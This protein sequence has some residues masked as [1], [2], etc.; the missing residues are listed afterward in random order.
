M[1]ATPTRVAQHA[2]IG[3]VGTGVMGASMCAHLQSAGHPLTVFTRTKAK[4]AAL[5]CAGAAWAEC[6]RAVAEQC[7][8]VCSMVGFPQDVRSVYFG[9]DG[10]LAGAKRGAVLIDFTT[11]EPSLAAEIAEAAAKQDAFAIDAPVSGGDVGARNATLSIMLGGD[12]TAIDAVMPL[13]KRLGK[14][15]IRQGGPG[16][17]QHAKMCNQIVIA[18]T[19]VGTCEALIYGHRAGLDLETMLSSIRGGAAGCWSLENY[20]PRILKRDFAPGFFVEHFVKDMGIALKEAERLNVALPG[21]ALAQQ[22]YISLKA[23]GH[24]R[25]G[26]QALMLALENLSHID[27]LKGPRI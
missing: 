26:T 17:G 1:S 12:A 23:Q 9:D 3:W 14:S 5:L 2:P 10:V 6:P 7:A 27:A 15:I 4:A 24:G 22:L 16:A 8:L 18:T 20:A 19:M 21:L 13:L 11:T 25:K